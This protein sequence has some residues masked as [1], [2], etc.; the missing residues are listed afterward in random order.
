MKI[1]HQAFTALTGSA[2]TCQS[3]SKSGLALSEGLSAPA[4]MF[5]MVA[6]YPWR[7][8]KFVTLKHFNKGSAP[9]EVMFTPS[10]PLAAWRGVRHRTLDRVITDQGFDQVEPGARRRRNDI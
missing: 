3:I 2:A 10:S 7:A 4:L 5:Q 6:E 8:W 9:G 1:D